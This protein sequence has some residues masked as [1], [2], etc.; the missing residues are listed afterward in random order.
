MALRGM[1]K[2]VVSA[3]ISRVATGCFML[4]VRVSRLFGRKEREGGDSN[5]YPFHGRL[6]ESAGQ[7]SGRHRKRL[8]LGGCGTSLE[9]RRFCR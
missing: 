1:V 9:R 8:S 4:A 6:L 2:R 5:A 7:R 3:G